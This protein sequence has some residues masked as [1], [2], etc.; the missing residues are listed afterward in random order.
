MY[1]VFGTDKFYHHGPSAVRT[2]GRSRG[3]SAHRPPCGASLAIL[4]GLRRRWRSVPIWLLSFINFP[5]ISQCQDGCRAQ[6]S[7]IVSYLTFPATGKWTIKHFL[8]F[9]IVLYGRDSC[10]IVKAS[11]SGTIIKG[12]FRPKTANRLIINRL[13]QKGKYIGSCYKR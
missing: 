13:W 1:K 9:K 7:P 2:E 6:N 3:E 8:Y 10:R 12:I 4:F 11:S 5:V